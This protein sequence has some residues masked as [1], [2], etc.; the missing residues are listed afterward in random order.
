MIVDLKHSCLIGSSED[1]L[2]FLRGLQS[3]GVLDMKFATVSVLEKPLDTRRIE[4]EIA[5]KVSESLILQKGKN[6]GS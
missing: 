3:S 1:I 6:L 5:K 2:S 4:E